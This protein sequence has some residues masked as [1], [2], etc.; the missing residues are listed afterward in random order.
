MSS[1]QQYIVPWTVSQ[2]VSLLLLFLSIKK[3]VLTRYLFAFIFVA[4]GFFNMITSILTP[5][6][7]L[8]YANTAVGVYR[9][10]INGWF[11]DHISWFVPLIATGQVLIGIGLMYG[12]SWLALGCLGIIIF[13]LAIAP[14]GIGSAFPFS[15]TV[16]VAAYFVYRHWQTRWGTSESE[17]RMNLPGDEIVGKPHFKATRAITINAKPE[18]IFPWIVQI[19]SKRAGWYSIDWMDNGGVISSIEILPQF[20]DI[21]KDQFIPF[22]P[23]Q[24]N[25]MWVKDFVMGKFILWSD[26]EGKASWCW[27]LIPVDDSTTRLLTRLRTRYNWKSIWIIYYLIYDAGDIIMMSKCMKGIKKRAELHMHGS[28]MPVS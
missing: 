20:Q 9:D 18:E 7:Y 1:L 4:A 21:E 14:L 3:P 6:V 27:Y 26:R 22:T 8:M 15:L 2:A 17:F 5:E 28:V 24:K 13:L 23:D 25:G 10:F 12:K 19:G 16:S 11:K